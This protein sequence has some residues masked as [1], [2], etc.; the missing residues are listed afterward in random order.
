MKNEVDMALVSEASRD[1]ARGRPTLLDISLSCQDLAKERAELRK[2]VSEID[3]RLL[4]LRSKEKPQALILRKMEAARRLGE[5][6]VELSELNKIQRDINGDKS[7]PYR[8]L[9]THQ[10]LEVIMADIA[11]IKRKLQSL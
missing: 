4:K 5:I 3:L 10:M 11:T 8:H 7:K 6:K 2:E 1:M 9:S